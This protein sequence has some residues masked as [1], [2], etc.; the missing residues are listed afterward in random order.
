MLSSLR[1]QVMHF[2]LVP[3]LLHFVFQHC[4]QQFLC[5]FGNSH[6]S[7]YDDHCIRHKMPKIMVCCPNGINVRGPMLVQ[8]VSAMAL[9]FPKFW[10]FVYRHALLRIE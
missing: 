7:L 3:K 10:E 8:S 4:L 2:Q 5:A 9:S 6:S 1:L